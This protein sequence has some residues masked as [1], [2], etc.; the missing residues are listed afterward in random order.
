MEYMLGHALDIGLLAMLILFQPEIRRAL[1]QFGQT[2]LGIKIIG[3][4]TPSNDAKQKWNIAIEAIC[5][6]C[7]ELSA[8]CTGALI[9]IER[10]TKLGE[11]IESGTILKHFS[12]FHVCSPLSELRL[13]LLKSDLFPLILQ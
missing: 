6:S 13:W 9:V 11:Q 2:K 4:G 12:V 5:D 3:I 1:E 8:S 7:V 10:Q